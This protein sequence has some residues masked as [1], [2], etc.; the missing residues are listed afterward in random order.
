VVNQP[1]KKKDIER[2]VQ[3]VPGVESVTDQ[4]RVLPLSPQDDRLRMQVARAVYGDP[5]LNRY[6]IQALPPI[7]IIVENGHVTLDGVV[8]SNLEKQVAGMRASAAGLSFGPVT[9]NLRVENQPGKKS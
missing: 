1:Y 9:N 3:Q 2:I 4:I 5:S 6:A 8:N 7:H